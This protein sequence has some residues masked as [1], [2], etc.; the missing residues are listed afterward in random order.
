[1]VQRRS[2]PFLIAIPRTHTRSAPAGPP[3][4]RRTAIRLPLNLHSRERGKDPARFERL[5]RSP[6]QEDDE[7]SCERGAGAAAS[8]VDVFLVSLARTIGVV[9]AGDMATTR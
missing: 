8:I 7:P 5:R 4:A 1:M 3:T 2:L 6:V 9:A